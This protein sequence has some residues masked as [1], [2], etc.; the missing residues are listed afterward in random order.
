MTW[1][2]FKHCG[3]SSG[4]ILEMGVVEEPHRENEVPRF[5]RIERVSISYTNDANLH[6]MNSLTSNYDIKKMRADGNCGYRCPKSWNYLYGFSNRHHLYQHLSESL[7]SV[8]C[9]YQDLTGA[10]LPAKNNRNNKLHRKVSYVTFIIPWFL[11]KVQSNLN[12]QSF[13]S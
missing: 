11:W 13:N 12:S 2:F 7:Q 4:S 5:S 6:S 9:P 8:W 3:E 10:T 1:S